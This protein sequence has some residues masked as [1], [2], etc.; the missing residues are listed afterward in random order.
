MGHI[1]AYMIPVI[2]YIFKTVFMCISFTVHKPTFGTKN[3]YNGTRILINDFFGTGQTLRTTGLNPV[4]G[5]K[6]HFKYPHTKL[7]TLNRL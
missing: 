1:Y 5:P 4:I 6:F 7:I 3:L 2:Y